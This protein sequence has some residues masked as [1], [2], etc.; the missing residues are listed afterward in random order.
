[1]SVTGF[2]WAS[3]FTGLLHNKAGT[4]S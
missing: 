3:R 1:M 4:P 2:S